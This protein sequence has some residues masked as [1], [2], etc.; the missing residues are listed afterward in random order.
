MNKILV[1]FDFSDISRNALLYS[2]KLAKL[3]HSEL[4][5]VSVVP[6]ME[7]VDNNIYNALY[8]PDYV[9]HKRQMLAEVVNK[10]TRRSPFRAQYVRFDTL[11]GNVVSEIMK[12]AKKNKTDLI[13][14]GTTSVSAT[15]EF[16]FGST[17][18]S[19]LAN[20]EIPMLVVPPTAKIAT[21]KRVIF[22]T[23]LNPKISLPSKLLIQEFC[24][25]VKTK[26]NLLHVR[27]DD[28]DIQEKKWRAVEELFPGKTLARHVVHSKDIAQAIGIFVES[29]NSDLLIAVRHKHSIVFTLFFK[30]MTKQLLSKFKIPLLILTE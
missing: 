13:V 24:V 29:I 15:G 28:T 27:D 4:H 6:P 12:Y 18:A 1:A 14:C 16:F 9:E 8:F 19:L 3:F 30:R 11:A 21:M 10:L 5:V 2:F 22:A 26:I 17:T 20:T 25:Q 23:D 7:H